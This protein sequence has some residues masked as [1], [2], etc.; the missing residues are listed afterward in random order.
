MI[1][2]ALADDHDLIAAG[3]ANMFQSFDDI[4]ICGSFRD[5][6]SLLNGLNEANPDVVLLDINMPGMKGD[7]V[8]QKLKINYPSLKIIVL[9][10]F[11]NVFNIKGMLRHRVDGYLLKNVTAESLVDAIRVVNQGGTYMDDQVTRII[12]ED[13]R[14]TKKQKAA[15]TLLTKR[16]KEILEL[17]AKNYT[18]SQIAEKL[19]VSR[20][21]VE[22]HRQSILDK[23]GVQKTTAMVEKAAQLNLIP[24]Y[25][26]PKGGCF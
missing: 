17:I 8:A 13:E 15:G 23:F 6:S 10:S 1:K 11:D 5:G 14:I 16:E 2:V 3:I 24:A 21:T 9:T 4:E 22:H 12:T 7:E 19:F 25:D 20:R 18:C 26:I